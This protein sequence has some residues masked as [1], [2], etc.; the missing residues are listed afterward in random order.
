[1]SNCLLQLLKGQ[2]NNHILPF[3]WIHGE[4]E[5]VLRDRIKKIS[6]SGIG[7]VCVES[8]THEDFVGPMWW[9]DMDIIMEEARNRN[10]KVWVLDDKHFPTGSVAGNIKNFYPEYRKWYL[11]QRQIDAV[12]PL[13]GASFLVADHL[14][15]EEKLVAVIATRRMDERYKVDDTLLDITQNIHNGVLYWDVPE[16]HW[17]VFL[18]IMTREGEKLPDHLNPIVP[19][20]VRVL[21]DTVYETHYE[22]YED[23]FGKTFAGFFS[24][25]SQFGNTKDFSAIIGKSNM[26][27]PWKEDMLY[28]LSDDL[29]E[30][31]SRYL[32]CL[33]NEA[34]EKTYSMRYTYMRV[35]SEL[36]SESFS[37]QLGN[38]CREHGVEYIGHVMEDNNVHARLG[39]GTGHFF[40]S[41]WGQDM[42]GIDVVL[43]QIV[44]G[45]DMYNYKFGPE[46]ERFADFY[47]YG[48]AKMGS[49]LGH[50]DPKKKGR[51]LCEMFGAYGWY[52]GLKLMKWLT[53]HMLVRG[54]NYFTPHAFT[55]KNHPD[56]DCPPHFYAEG[57][58]AQFRYFKILME[59]TNRIANLF[60]DGIHIA[61][62]AV[63]Y[64]AEAEWSGECMF[65][66]EPV[67]K[68]MQHQIDCDILPS[69]I[70]GHSSAKIQ[71]RALYVNNEKYKCLIIPYAEALP[72]YIMDAIIEAAKKGLK[73]LF[74]NGLPSRISDGGDINAYINKLNS[75]V[76]CQVVD[77]ER[78]VEVLRKNQ[79]QEIVLESEQPYLRFYHYQKE[80]MDIFMF[81]N[82]H[83]YNAIDT[84][85]DIPIDSE[86]YVY[87][88]FENKLLKKTFKK[89]ER[90]V[91]IPARLECY[92]SIILV[93][94]EVS[95]SIKS[96]EIGNEKSII[97][98]DE[99][100]IRGEWK[101][102]IATAKE[103]PSF[104]YWKT[105][106]D[107]DSLSKPHF[108][109]Q[110][111]GT[112][113]YEIEFN[114]DG[115]SNV[116]ILDLGYVYEIAEVW[117]NNQH[118]G[119]RICPPYK[120]NITNWLLKGKNKLCIDVTN[121]L[122]KE[123]HDR[124]S[125]LAMQEPSGLMGPVV[126]Y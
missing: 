4:K 43:Q 1:M 60:S 94:G 68:M 65:F 44:P 99:L 46:R 58:N 5:S 34:G 74:V 27:I 41:L 124:F 6:E 116:Q 32:P 8:R 113:R 49:S 57:Y 118:L 115:A 114:W 29:G 2:Y 63:L 81:F 9:R 35:V 25:E 13:K 11:M 105:N 28:D 40:R 92:E 88:A 21:I 14:K 71:S 85:I 66:Q 51:T 42:S 3:L 84:S 56:P 119:V 55:T 45:Y 96:L 16:G 23:D 20:A 31:F 120:F 111:S 37:M 82:E 121:T 19:R 38:W 36:Y 18:F 53:D 110:F 97:K 103:Y 48:L 77:I 70:F 102:S 98:K 33:W 108:L 87:N 26:V 47:H 62:A 109:P 67:K 30:D 80:S 122:V 100:E 125:I 7:A 15:E 10:M 39:W 24:D 95:T 91:R 72:R 54:V 112:F 78:L 50:I 83:P 104:R 126:M 64:H 61:S 117:I 75:S 76:E 73:V 12:G 90:G 89:T 106:F 101:I 86:V 69:D 123:Q 93:L 52:E 17:R 79:Y 59:Y 22:R 107:L